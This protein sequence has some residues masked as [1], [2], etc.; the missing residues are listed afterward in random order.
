MA[1]IKLPAGVF[2]AVKSGQPV[3]AA[4]PAPKADAAPAATETKTEPKTA[5]AAA[6]APKKEPAVK[7]GADETIAAPAEAKPT[8]AE[9]RVLKLK[10]DGEEFDF[11]LSDEAA[12]KRE[13]Q[14]ARA[15]DKR[16]QEAAAQ[17]KQAETFFEMLKNPATLRQVLTDPRVGVDVKKFAEEFVWE[18]IEQQKREEEWAKNPEKKA[19]WEREQKL[20]AYEEAEA[21]AREEAT[22]RG[23]REATARFETD[24][25]AKI[26]QA[27]KLG[28]IP[29]TE[30][31]VARMAEELHLAVENGIDLDPAELVDK[32]RGDYRGD[33]MALV[34]ELS[35]DQIIE[36]FGENVAKKIREADLKKLRSPTDHPFPARTRRAAPSAPTEKPKRLSGSD[37]KADVAAAFL[38][39]K[40]G[41]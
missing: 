25:N 6:P 34:S 18:Q 4:A 36:L 20:K 32:V 41:T 3:P 1:D 7:P 35:G 27:L 15:A 30:Q 39:R 21:R 24:Y 40:S 28:G 29:Q 17:K 12:L 22:T 31:A 2:A 11:D 10:A 23:H 26:L 38:S 16:F 37:W 33:L 9:K 13:L 19:A 8:A 14:K 5:P